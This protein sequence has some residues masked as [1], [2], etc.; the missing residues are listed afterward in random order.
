[1]PLGKRV[2]M[3]ESVRNSSL[4]NAQPHISISVKSTGAPAPAANG[5]KLRLDRNE[6]GTVASNHSFGNLCSAQTTQSS[7]SKC[8][9]HKRDNTANVKGNHQSA[10]SNHS[11]F[12]ASAA[13]SNA[14][15][16]AAA[17]STGRIN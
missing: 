4:L 9:W 8:A 14:A 16:A 17:P 15:A 10:T 2:A 13:G 12:T 7:L 11:H 6:A 5:S 1:M 3:E